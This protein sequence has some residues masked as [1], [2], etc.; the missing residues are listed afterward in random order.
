MT[1]LNSL[2][3]GGTEAFE[4]SAKAEFARIRIKMATPICE[5]YRSMMPLI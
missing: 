4:A 5:L 3:S 1:N 2:E